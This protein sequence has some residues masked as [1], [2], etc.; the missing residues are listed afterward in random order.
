MVCAGLGRGRGRGGD[1]G[2]VFEAMPHEK[3]E[4]E[5]LDFTR[6]LTCEGFVNTSGA[7]MRTHIEVVGSMRALEPLA[8][9]ME[10]EDEGEHWETGDRALLKQRR[11]GFAPAM[12]AGRGEKV[13]G[14]PITFTLGAEAVRVR[15]G[16]VVVESGPAVRVTPRGRGGRS[17]KKA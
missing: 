5:L 13:E 2:V 7:P 10:V 1:E 15:G 14:P 4:P 9:S 6:S 16:S 12:K 17:G 8:K 11:E 3:C